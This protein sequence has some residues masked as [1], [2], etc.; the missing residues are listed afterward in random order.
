MAAEYQEPD[1]RVV[2]YQAFCLDPEIVDPSRNR[3]LRIRGPR[4][5]RL[6]PGEYFVCL[7]AAQTFGRFCR[8]PFPTLLSERLGLPVLNISHGGAGPSFFSREPE[9]LLRYLDGARFVVLQAMSGRSESNSLFESD[10]VGHYRRRADGREIGC[11]AA[12][13]ELIRIAPPSVVERVVEETRRNWIASYRRLL[14]RMTAP[15]L[16]FW[17]ST[18]RP[19]YRQGADGVSALFGEFPQLVNGA[20]IE[21]LRPD[22]DSVVSCVSRRGLPQILRDYRTG[23][24]VTVRDEWTATP[25]EVNAYYPSPEMHEDAADALEG[26]CRRLA[27]LDLRNTADPLTRMAAAWRGLFT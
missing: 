24:P 17:F 5:Q 16:L 3:P 23:E 20:M 21:A 13:D 11:D 15:N 9:A 7:G 8:R 25:W 14:A 12:F 1:I 22:C 4:P 27:G 18:R 10:G 2:D 6:E 19:S 26:P